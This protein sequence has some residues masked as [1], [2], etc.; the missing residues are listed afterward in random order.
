MNSADYKIGMIVHGAFENRYFQGKI[1]SLFFVL[2]SDSGLVPSAQVHL[3]PDTDNFVA[4]EKDI[5]VPVS[6]F[7]DD[8]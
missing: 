6:C 5:T 1:S 2:D 3:F 8:E 7:E 4:G